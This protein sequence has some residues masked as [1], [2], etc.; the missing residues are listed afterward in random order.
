V[1]FGDSALDFSLRFWTADFDNWMTVQS[2]VLAAVEA[3][4]RAAGL[5][6][7]FPQRDLHLRSIDPAARQALRDAPQPPPAP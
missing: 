4:L 7:P 5:E 1:G 2:D 3:A 6:I